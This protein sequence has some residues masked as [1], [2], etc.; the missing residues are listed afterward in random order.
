MYVF[1]SCAI[2]WKNTIS[3][4][5][6]DLSGQSAV[7]RIFYEKTTFIYNEASKELLI[8]T[9]F[10]SLTHFSAIFNLIQIIAYKCFTNAKKVF[11]SN[12]SRVGR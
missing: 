8:K 3:Q 11:S 12:P 1:S 4:P 10:D 6:F 9:S 7:K 5:P 2:S